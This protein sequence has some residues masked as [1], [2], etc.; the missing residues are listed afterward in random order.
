[1]KGLSV[2]AKMTLWYGA[3][4]IVIAAAVAA[5]LVFATRYIAGQ[6]IKE[7]LK[8]AVEDNAP[9]IEVESGRL[10]ISNHLENYKDGKYLL[11]YE[12][13]NFLISGVAPED[14]PEDLAF[15][16]GKLRRISSRGTSYYVYDH[17]IKTRHFV[18]VWLRGISAAD[19]SVVSPAVDRMTVL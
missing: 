14:F 7:E 6:D 18:D 17:K 3:F 13:G 2:K 15:R 19:L 4:L 16:D 12:E 9:K 11:V 5:A 8:E 1:M 10:Y